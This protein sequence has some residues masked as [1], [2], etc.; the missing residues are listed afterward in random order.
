M[1]GHSC[2]RMQRVL[3]QFTRS[4]SEGG[5]H[6]KVVIAGGGTGGCSVGARACRTFGRG[7][8]A[9]IEPA[10]H[11]YYQPMWT[12]V[13]AGIKQVENSSA[14]MKDV[15][16]SGCHH[17][18]QRV[19]EFNPEKNTVILS[20]GEKLSYDYLVI[21]L[22]IQINLNKVEGLIPALKADRNV[23]TNYVREYVEKTFP[24][25]Q[26][27]RGGN[28]I[29]TF[30]NT[31][32]KCAGA[33]QKIMY[34]ADEYWRKAGVRDKATVMFNTSLGVI[35]GVKKYAASLMPIVERKGIQLNLRRNLVSVDHSKKTATFEL[36]DSEKGEK[37]TYDY[38]FLHVAPP[39]SAPDIL[40]N[41]T[42]PIV[43]ASGFLDV[44]KLTCQHNK[45]PNIFGVGD[46]TNIPTAKTAAAIASQNKIVHTGIKEVEAGKQP[47]GQY[48]GYT[49]CPLITGYHHCIL[50]EF[51]FEGVPLETFPLNQAKERRTMF[52]MKKDIMP[53]IY[54][55]MLLKGYWGGPKPYRK[56]MHLGTG[57]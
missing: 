49:S 18:E 55:N 34:L 38:D 6:Y 14:L 3:V 48:D 54:W 37:I 30:P 46:C 2:R 44:N 32:I 12:L 11:H 27:F 47:S 42:S 13:G 57:K 29:F 5:R 39:M 36:L 51:G 41:S 43:D 22:G 50:A 4:Y 10:K 7:N 52:H 53:E 15:L 20:N 56:I 9:I 8:V 21:G 16:P 26:D 33:P 45:F 24:A 31:P 17:Y 1:S 40:K 19:Q 28:A 35:F 25:I 23:C